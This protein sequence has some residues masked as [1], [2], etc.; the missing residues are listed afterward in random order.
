MRAGSDLERRGAAQANLGMYLP[1][2]VNAGS[3]LRCGGRSGLGR[4]RGRL[5][6][7]ER[8]VVSGDISGIGF[9]AELDLVSTGADDAL[10]HDGHAVERDLEGE[11]VADNF[12]VADGHGVA[13]RTQNGAGEGFAVL[14]EGELKL[15]AVAVGH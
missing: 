3:G 15:E 2:G 14:L 5:D 10:V 9:G 8:H 7:L 11:L 6:P 4:R 13:L 12:A 1:R